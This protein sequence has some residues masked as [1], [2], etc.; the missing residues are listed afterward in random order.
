MIVSAFRFDLALDRQRFQF[1]ILPSLRPR[2]ILNRKTLQ[3]QKP[4]VVVPRTQRINRELKSGTV[5]KSPSLKLHPLK[6]GLDIVRE[7]FIP[8][9]SDVLHKN[10]IRIAA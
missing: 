7:Q 4:V 8:Q 2:H 3:F 6:H 10:Q 1:P 5:R 9:P